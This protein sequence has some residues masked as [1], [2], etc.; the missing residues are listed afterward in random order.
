VN[1]VAFN[2]TILVLLLAIA[3]MSYPTPEYNPYAPPK[4]APPPFPMYQ[5]PYPG[6]DPLFGLFRQGNVLVM[7]RSA[8]LPDRCI[9]SNEPANGRTLRRTLRWHPPLVYLA[10]LVNLLVYVV[11][12]AILTKTATIQIGLT[13]RWIAKRRMVMAIAWLL[14]LVGVGMFFGSFPLMDPQSGV[15]PFVMLGGILVGIG[16][17]I[18]GILAAR[19]VYPSKITDTHIWL[20]GVHPDFLNGLPNWPMPF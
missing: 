14:A 7:H 4:A 19:L 2:S 3:H 17:A 8:P 20:N 13:E 15:G 16:G 5:Q 9:K 10:L 18:Y 6:G 11:L 12:A 1:P